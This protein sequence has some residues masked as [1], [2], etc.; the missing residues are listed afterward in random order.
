MNSEEDEGQGIKESTFNKNKKVNK[1]VSISNASSF[2]SMKR[3]L[4][5]INKTKG[6]YGYT[7]T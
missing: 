6:L 5:C 4:V 1:H 3:F 2:L 7:T